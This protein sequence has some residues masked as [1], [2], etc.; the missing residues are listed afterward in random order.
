MCSIKILVT[1]KDKHRVLKSDILTPIQT[2][3]AIADEK[4]EKMIGDDTG[5]NVSTY[6]PFL[7]EMSALYW[8]WKNYDKLGNPDYIGHMHYRRQFLFDT[9][10]LKLKHRWLSSY[11]K[12]K[13]FTPQIIDAF[14]DERIREFVP[15]YDYIISDWFDA[16]VYGHKNI[17]EDY[18]K[19]PGAKIEI[20]DEFIKICKEKSPEYMEEIEQIEKGTK[21]LICIM[22]IMKKD[23]FFEFCEFA[24]PILFELIDRIGDEN[25][26]TN[27]QRYAGYMAEKLLSIYVLKLQKNKQLKMKILNC[28]FMLNPDETFLQSILN[29]IFSIKKT[30]DNHI[31]ITILGVKIKVKIKGNS[32]K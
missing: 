2:G 4:F 22:F 14:S 24:F 13:R 23:L 30:S 18:S 3:R 11:Y 10:N 28:S 21:A 20:F 12:F 29:S 17:R 32:I 6:N 26:T 1:Y 25:L 16:T 27:G 9:S 7:C 19:I 8:A 5:D 31:N 15:N